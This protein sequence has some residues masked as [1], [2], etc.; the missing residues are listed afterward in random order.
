M[1]T[2]DERSAARERAEPESGMPR[3]VKI[4]MIAVA[5]AVVVVVLVKVTGGGGG[6]GPGLHGAGDR[7]LSEVVAV[8]PHQ[9][10]LPHAR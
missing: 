8:A 7:S 1:A 5:I 9:A 3:W 10:P 2:E 6:H 4:S